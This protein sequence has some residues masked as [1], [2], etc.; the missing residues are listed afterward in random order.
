VV[1][2]VCAIKFQHLC[3]DPF[4]HSGERKHTEN[5]QN[6]HNWFDIWWWFSNT[7]P[8]VIHS[9]NPCQVSDNTAWSS[10]T[11]D[12]STT[13]V[14]HG[15]INRHIVPCTTWCQRFYRCWRVDIQRFSSTFTRVTYP[16]YTACS[17]WTQDESAPV[18]FRYVAKQIFP[19]TT[20]RQQFS[21]CQYF[22]EFTDRKLCGDN[23]MRSQRASTLLLICVIT[24]VRITCKPEYAGPPHFSWGPPYLVKFSGCRGGRLRP[25]T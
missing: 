4:C 10:R 17:S 12:E 2:K 21:Q 15:Y 13:S 7:S 22:A 14:L 18:V 24:S 1:T 9:D 20:W 5:I 11:T 16:N 3:S 8:R 23:T 6:S 25:H 19:C